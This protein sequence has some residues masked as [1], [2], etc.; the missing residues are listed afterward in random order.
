MKPQL[1][2]LLKMAYTAERQTELFSNYTHTLSLI[3]AAPKPLGNQVELIC[4]SKLKPASDIKALYDKGI[5]HFGEN[6]VQELVAKS[7]ELPQDIKWHFIGGLQTNKCKDLTKIPNLWSAQTVDSLKKCKKFEESRAKDGGD[8]IK[9]FL[10][11]NTS[12]EEQ[13]SGLSPQSEE[14]AEIVEYL[15]Q[16]KHV[17]YEGLMTIGSFDH[18]H[19]EGEEN[20][21]FTA[22]SNLKKQLDAKYG[23]QSKLSMGMSSDYEQAITQGANYVRVGTDIFGSRN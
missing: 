20:P 4:V 19:T 16:C 10:Q 12:G 6:Y 5:R 15:Q 9:V 22:L 23:F 7:K 18:S 21:D 2:Q 13:K 8:T 14:L 1:I 3:D 11:I 17:E